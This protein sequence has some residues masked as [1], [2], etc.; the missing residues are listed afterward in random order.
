MNKLLIPCLFKNTILDFFLRFCAFFVHSFILSLAVLSLCCYARAF[1]S[2]GSRVYCLTVLP[3]GAR[4]LGFRLQQLWCP[5][6]AALQHAEPYRTRG[7]THVPCIGRQILFQ[8]FLNFMFIDLLLAALGLH[9]YIWTF[10]SC[11]QW[12][13]LFTA[14]RRLLL[15]VTV[16][17]VAEHRPQACRFQQMLTWAQQLWHIGLSCSTAC[18]IF[19]DQGLHPCFLQILNH[20]TT[21]EVLLCWFFISAA[22]IF[23]C[24]G[25]HNNVA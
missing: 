10:S 17:L 3:C 23:I 13:L 12:R 16:S 19:L 9:C 6:L 15:I 25:Y 20:W 11:G 5:G 8:V 2:C 22:I 4:A 1:S 14:V 21:R 7:Q 18:E 24:Q